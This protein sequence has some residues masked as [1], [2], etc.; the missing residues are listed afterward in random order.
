VDIKQQQA[1][2]LWY[3]IQ[4]WRDIII[5][6]LSAL[7]MQFLLKELIDGAYFSVY[8]KAFFLSGIGL[9]FMAISSAFISINHFQERLSFEIAGNPHH[10][11]S[12]IT[13]QVLKIVSFYLGLIDLV[14]IVCS[15]V[16]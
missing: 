15:F 5:I 3:A 10:D 9:F 7:F 4:L 2:K 14:V 1:V 12:E 11:L 8:Q 13:I 6:A 16:F